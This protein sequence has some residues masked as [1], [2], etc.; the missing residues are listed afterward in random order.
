M[1]LRQALEIESGPPDG[2]SRDFDVDVSV[3]VSSANAE[4]RRVGRRPSSSVCVQLAVSQETG[5]LSIYPS[6][7]VV[8]ATPFITKKEAA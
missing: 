2:K 1:K 7:T 8:D 5:E 6:D 3:K 4:Q